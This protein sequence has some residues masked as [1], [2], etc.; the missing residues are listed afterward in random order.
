MT[1][2]VVNGKDD[3]DVER[4]FGGGHGS[5]LGLRRIPLWIL[6]AVVLLQPTP[7]RVSQTVAGDLGDSMFLTWTLSWGARGLTRDPFAVFD[8]NIFHPE[9]QT[10]ALSDP[11]LSVAPF[12]GLVEWA[13]GDSV[14]ALN[15]TMFV[16][17][18]GALAA[19]HALAMRIFGR[20]DIAL[21]VAV[22]VCANSYVFGGQ[23]HPQ[24]QT[25]GFVPLCFL[26][27][28]R[29]LELRRRRDGAWLGLAV[30][31]MTLANVYYGLI[32]VLCALAVVAT[33]WLRGVLAPM[34]GLVR[35]AIP[36]AAVAVAFLGPVVGVFRA[37]DE[38]NG[39]ARG[40][41]PQSSLLPTDLLTPQRDNWSWGTA[42]DGI[43]SFGKAGEHAYFPGFLA[44]A[45]GTVGIFVLWRLFR[46]KATVM[47]TGA[48]VDELIAIVAAGAVALVL[49]VGPSP[50]GVSGPFR[51]LHR[52]VP[53]FN[54]IRVTSRFTVIT[55]VAAALLVGLAVWV[56]IDRVPT[57][58]RRWVAPAVVVMV[59][60]EVGGPMARVEVPEGDR[61]LV[62]EALARLDEGPVLELPIQAPSAGAQWAFVEAPRM[63]HATT[64]WNREGQRLLRQF[65]A[66]V[67]GHRPSVEPLAVGRCR[68]ARRRPRSALRDPAWWR[69]TGHSGIDTE[70]PGAARD[71][72]AGDR[73][74]GDAVRRGLARHSRVNDPEGSGSLEYL[75]VA[76]E[77]E[78]CGVV[79]CGRE[80]CRDGG[81]DDPDVD[82]H[83]PVHDVGRA[84]MTVESR[85]EPGLD[86][87][88]LLLGVARRRGAR[89]VSLMSPWRSGVGAGVTS[90]R[91]MLAPS[92]DPTN[93]SRGLS[94]HRVSTPGTSST[95]VK[96]SRSIRSGAGRCTG[97][98]RTPHTGEAG[99]RA[100]AG[101]DDDAGRDR[102][103]RDLLGEGF[104]RSGDLSRE[105]LH[106]EQSQLRWS[107][108]GNRCRCRRGS[109]SFTGVALRGGSAAGAVVSFVPARDNGRR[110]VTAVGEPGRDDEAGDESSSGACPEPPTV[111]EGAG[112]AVVN[113]LAEV[114]RRVERLRLVG[115]GR[116]QP[117]CGR[118]RHR[119]PP[120]SDSIRACARD[121]ADFD[122]SD[123]HVEKIG[124]LAGLKVLVVTEDENRSLSPRDTL[125]RGPHD[126]FVVD[127]T[128]EVR[129]CRGRHDIVAVA[130]RVPTRP[131]P[132]GRAV[133]DG[134][135][136]YASGL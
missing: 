7:H 136:G 16:L 129:R 133:R 79:D 85:G 20:G 111:V 95:V 100:V 22:V 121:P 68:G 112:L 116:S 3:A 15:V 58:V 76:D 14:V 87:L 123:G 122:R 61:L 134:S 33:L 57:S 91:V 104:E 52:F 49:A 132:P 41:E 77:H 24:L 45:L 96:V 21:V 66:G 119:S 6:L 109:G 8:A 43:N 102:D 98:Q 67:R 55:F 70:R 74:R 44:L 4:R 9:P 36:A 135:S 103:D 53:G 31:A 84:A 107:R 113:A 65:A 12:F 62:Y 51:V 69:R 63:Y 60:V 73:P 110:V 117:V 90:V 13:T 25:F 83:P 88:E 127:E 38:R 93:R 40:Y 30:V 56:V 131:G 47:H 128:R 10:L 89:G 19:A 5:S 39:L 59:L 26:L 92:R 34:R 29:A 75:G 99:L 105:S 42:L 82:D 23:N 81:V 125:Q 101:V 115:Q 48:R 1:G 37:V 54:G 17:F 27:L 86:D 18:V 130:F 35:P 94:T 28:L 2:L 126:L 32:W 114:R 72:G 50:G 11:M 120:S 46:R 118:E 71:P 80:S 64:D 108:V 106:A 97:G 124:N 78:W